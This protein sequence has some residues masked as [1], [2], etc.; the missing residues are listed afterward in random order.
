MLAPLTTKPQQQTCPQDETQL[1]K[2]RI[3]LCNHK[4]LAR[5]SQTM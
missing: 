5:L 3:K 2:S 4:F 1:V